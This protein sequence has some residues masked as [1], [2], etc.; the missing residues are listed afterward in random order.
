MAE[1]QRVAGRGGGQDACAVPGRTA[2]LKRTAQVRD[3]RLHCGER[4]CRRLIGIQI[5][6]Q[7]VGGDH[8]AVSG[9]QPGQHAPLPR[10][11]DAGWNTSTVTSSGPSTLTLITGT[12][13]TEG[14]TFSVAVLAS[15][16]QVRGKSA[17][18]SP[19]QAWDVTSTRPFPLRVKTA[20]EPEPDLTSMVVVHR[21]IRQD[22]RRL[23]A[24]LA[25]IAGRGS[26]PSQARAIGRYTAALLAEIRAHHENEDEVLW[27]VIAATAG[28]AVDLAPLRH[29]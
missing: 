25:E 7:P 14:I 8:L 19:A 2:R 18:S 11:A 6:D 13:L 20:A 21:A 10:P 28:Q 5:L 23:A 16:P 22:L 4:F 1:P 17:T 27:P 9:D 15:L 12:S 24:C 26:S 3:V 29:A